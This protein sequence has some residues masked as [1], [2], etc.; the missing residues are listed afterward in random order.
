MWK[1]EPI[2]I[3]YMLLVIISMILSWYLTKSSSHI[4]MN[5][6]LFAGLIAIC[7]CLLLWNTYA[8]ERTE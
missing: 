1:A 2:L 5:N 7:V 6:S 3:F 4:A 8:S